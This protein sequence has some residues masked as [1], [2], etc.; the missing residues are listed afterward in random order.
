[1]KVNEVCRIQGEDEQLLQIMLNA[2]DLDLSFSEDPLL[3]T[4]R[5]KVSLIFG[6]PFYTQVKYLEYENYNLKV[7]LK[8]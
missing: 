7:I 5:R 6:V 4:P 8:M 3:R 2:L 1:M